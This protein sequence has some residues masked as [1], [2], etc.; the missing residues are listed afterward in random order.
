MNGR[1]GIIIWRSERLACAA[2]DLAQDRHRPSLDG[3]TWQ[4]SGCAVGGK[5][6]EDSDWLSQR[7]ST[8]GS[9]NASLRQ[10]GISQTS[11]Y[12]HERWAVRVRVINDTITCGLNRGSR[13]QVASTT[14]LSPLEIWQSAPLLNFYT[15]CLFFNSFI[16]SNWGNEWLLPLHLV[17]HN[18]K[19]EHKREHSW[20]VSSRTSHKLNFQ[21]LLYAIKRFFI[22]HMSLLCNLPLPLLLI[23]TA[24]APRLRGSTLG[25]LTSHPSIN[26]KVY[27][28]FLLH[29]SILPCHFS[30]ISYIFFFPAPTSYIVSLFSHHVPFC[31]ASPIFILSSRI[32]ST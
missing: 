9:P 3:G 7:G 4:E 14:Y 29:S 32:R 1:T 28:H 13:V 6:G 17:S 19:N 23:F 25:P 21:M 22:M 24:P 30:T 12:K 31:L 11:I 5:A 26:P 16:A 8:S 15:N 10:A 18:F 2:Q 27:Q 20:T